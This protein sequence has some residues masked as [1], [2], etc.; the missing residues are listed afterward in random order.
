MILWM[1]YNNLRKKSDFFE[2]Y[3]L[4]DIHLRSTKLSSLFGLKKLRV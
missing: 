3:M 4:E 2:K 1:L